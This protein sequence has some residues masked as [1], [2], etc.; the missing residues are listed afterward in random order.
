[1][2]FKAK[3]YIDHFT[4]LM[5]KMQKPLT[6]RVEQVRLFQADDCPLVIKAD[7]F[8]SEVRLW[9][10]MEQKPMLVPF[11]DKEWEGLGVVAVL[12]DT[13]AYLVEVLRSVFDTNSGKGGY[14]AAWTA[15]Q[16]EIVL[17]ELIYGHSLSHEDTRLSEILGTSACAVDTL[18]QVR[19]FLTLAPYSSATRE[20]RPPPIKN[21]TRDPTQTLRVERVFALT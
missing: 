13:M 3:Q 14:D 6:C 16:V 1:M 7:K 9:E 12:Q 10:L 20:I 2:Y 19:G 8:F 11:L 18:T 21:W 17:E 5:H 4:D 15:Y